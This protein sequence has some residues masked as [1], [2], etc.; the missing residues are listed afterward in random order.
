[1]YHLIAFG[2]GMIIGYYMNSAAWG[3][4]NENLW[5]FML[6]GGCIIEAIHILYIVFTIP[7]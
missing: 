1:M 4:D 5:N 2:I 7:N 6:L 3:D